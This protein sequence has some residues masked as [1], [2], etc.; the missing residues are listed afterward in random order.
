MAKGKLSRQ[1]LLW[2]STAHI[3]EAGIFIVKIT[4]AAMYGLCC[5][6]NPR[7]PIVC[8]TPKFPSH[9]TSLAHGEYI[10]HNFV[11]IK[12]SL[13]IKVVVWTEIYYFE[14]LYKNFP[15]IEKPYKSS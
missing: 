9:K 7:S 3:V 5:I 12:W 15:I 4:H 10:K 11:D 13:T 6:M 1:R 2:K 14:N 8:Q